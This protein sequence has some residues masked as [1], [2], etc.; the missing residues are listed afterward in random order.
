MIEYVNAAKDEGK[1][2]AA[3]VKPKRGQPLKADSSDSCSTASDI[4]SSSLFCG[5]SVKDLVKCLKAATEPLHQLVAEAEEQ[6]AKDSESDDVSGLEQKSETLSAKLKTQYTK[7]V[8]ALLAIKQAK[9]DAGVKKCTDGTSLPIISIERLYEPFVSGC[10]TEV[11]NVADADSELVK[12][13]DI[14][15]SRTANPIKTSSRASRADIEA[16]RD[17]HKQMLTSKDES[18]D[19]DDDSSSESSST[20]SSDDAEES[21]TEDDD[22]DDEYDPKKEIRQVKLERGHERRFSVKKQKM[23]AGM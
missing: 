5:T 6:L 22:D 20:S 1:A 23:R 3:L 2:K 15:S 18:S 8:D 14:S 16:Q 11:D 12:T 21:S 17:L 10:V 9:L 19:S 13:D 4:V 7:S